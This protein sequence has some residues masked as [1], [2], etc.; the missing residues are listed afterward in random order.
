MC[1]SL[2]SLIGQAKE[3]EETDMETSKVGPY[4]SI[5]STPLHTAAAVRF[6]GSSRLFCVF[7]VQINYRRRF[8]PCSVLPLTVLLDVGRSH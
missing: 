8:K 6:C 7:E 5:H 3:V 4:P 1:S 2:P